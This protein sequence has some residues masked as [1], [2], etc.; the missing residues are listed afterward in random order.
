MAI[1]QRPRDLQRAVGVGPVPV[2]CIL[3]GGGV[4]AVVRLTEDDNLPL[5]PLWV[6]VHLVASEVVAELE[7]QST[8][9]TLRV[10]RSNKA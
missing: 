9:T 1:G 2:H 5:V 4:L 7:L 3:L 6:C 8:V 10:N